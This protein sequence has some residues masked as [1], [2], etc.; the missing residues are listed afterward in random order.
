MKTDSLKELQNYFKQSNFHLSR[1]IS[2]LIV[3][4]SPQQIP[5]DP[6]K[7]IEDFAKEQN[8]FKK[9]SDPEINFGSVVQITSANG[10]VYKLTKE[11]VLRGGYWYL[12]MKVDPNVNIPNSDS[13][14][15]LQSLVDSDPNVEGEGVEKV[16]NFLKR[17][18]AYSG[19]GGQ[20]KIV[21]YLLS[22]HT[23]YQTDDFYSKHIK[24]LVL[25]KNEMNVIQIEK[26][27]VGSPSL[28][29]FIDAV[30]DIIVIGASLV[31]LAA[32][33]PVAIGLSL[34]NVLRKV[35][36][37]AM[38]VGI[39]NNLLAENYLEAILGIVGLLIGNP[40]SSKSLLRAYIYYFRGPNA[41]YVTSPRLLIQVP[42][43]VLAI[44]ASFM[45]TIQ[46]VIETIVGAVKD[47][48]K[49]VNEKYGIDKEFVTEEELLAAKNKA[50]EFER[51]IMEIDLSELAAA[52][53]VAESQLVVQTGA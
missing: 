11:D 45:E 46:Y 28:S 40:R 41:I 5:S 16:R 6:N 4:A 23:P 10:A 39:F 51:Y 25:V 48:Q 24:N 44:G 1:K 22:G 36:N 47:Y 37:A 20:S 26:F 18:R 34:V 38:L 15:S 33:G 49:E 30:S 27:D 21:T 9:I 19:V 2:K 29:D 7:A 14:T 35:A 13:I 8:A 32:T 12:C 3:T 31:A 53:S 50:G 43:Y 42:D 52:T 17:Y